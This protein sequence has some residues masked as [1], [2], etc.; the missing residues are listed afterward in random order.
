MM[1]PFVYGLRWEQKLHVTVQVI[2]SF[3]GNGVVAFART[4]T[5]L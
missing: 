1:S 4:K 3:A 2:D 5:R